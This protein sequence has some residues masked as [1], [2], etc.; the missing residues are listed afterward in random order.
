[1][2]FV[3]PS[4]CQEVFGLSIVEAM[5]FG[6]PCIGNCVGGIP[7]VIGDGRNGFLTKTM[8]VD[9]M[10]DAIIRMLEIMG[11]EEVFQDMSDEAKR[12]AQCFSIK[13]TC[14]VLDREVAGLARS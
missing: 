1:M 3:Y 13:S 4:I 14:R 9:G 8:D 2:L 12:T 5:A 11:D 7:E 6:I 10:Y